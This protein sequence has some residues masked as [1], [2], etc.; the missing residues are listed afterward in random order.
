MFFFPTIFLWGIGWGIDIEAAGSSLSRAEKESIQA[1]SPDLSFWSWPSSSEIA[2]NQKC[3]K[4]T[5]ILWFIGAY[6]GWNLIYN[7]RVFP[8]LRFTPTLPHLAEKNN[9]AADPSRPAADP[10][11][12]GLPMH[13]WA[14]SPRM[15]KASTDCQRATLSC[16]IYN[17]WRGPSCW[18]LKHFGALAPCCQTHG[19][20]RVE[21]VDDHDLGPRSH[22]SEHLRRHR[23]PFRPTPQHAQRNPPWGGLR[24]VFPNRRQRFKGLGHIEDKRQW[25][26]GHFWSIDLVPSPFSSNLHVAQGT[27]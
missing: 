24:R 13:S 20:G 7:D 10:S 17:W 27:I 11:R 8:D 26:A 15:C 4:V 5:E 12:P 3:E 9:P 14:I 23:D 19:R 2:A 1:T 21:Q 6:W 16:P 25:V 22:G 18:N